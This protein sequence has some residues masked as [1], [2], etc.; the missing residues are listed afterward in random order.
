MNNK[1][2][3]YL[4]GTGIKSSD[5]LNQLR[6]FVVNKFLK[7]KKKNALN[8]LITYHLPINYHMFFNFNPLHKLLHKTVVVCTINTFLP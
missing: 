3:S 2:N 5:Q 6:S 1:I 4:E 8:A 7:K